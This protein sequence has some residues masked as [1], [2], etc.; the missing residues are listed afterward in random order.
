MGSGGTIRSFESN[1]YHKPYNRV[2]NNNLH[3]FLSIPKM[4]CYNQRRGTENHNTEM[5]V[6]WTYTEE[7]VLCHR[8]TGP[9][10]KP[11]PWTMQERTTQKE[12]Q[13]NKGTR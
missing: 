3:I 10:L 5:E 13:D 8:E 11:P 4:V 6:D 1:K 2:Q 9:E 12:T 7:V